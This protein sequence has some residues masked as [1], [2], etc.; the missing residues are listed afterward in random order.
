[1]SGRT[2]HS[3]FA[4]S[5]FRISYLEPVMLYLMKLINDVRASVLNQHKKGASAWKIV[6]CAICKTD[7]D[8]YVMFWK[9]AAVTAAKQALA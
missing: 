8:L 3:A 7:I 1:M 6:Q 4:H 9:H 2:E 5:E